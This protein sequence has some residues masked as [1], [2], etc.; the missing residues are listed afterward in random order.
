MAAYD[1][2]P[3]RVRLA[4]AG[5]AFDYVPQPILTKLRRG[6][7]DEDLAVK[8]IAIWDRLEIDKAKRKRA[9]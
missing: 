7:F 6:I 1:K 3:P 4:L 8:L 2:L 9:R 5:A